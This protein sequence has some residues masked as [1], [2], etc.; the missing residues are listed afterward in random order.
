MDSDGSIKSGLRARPRGPRLFVA[1]YWKNNICIHPPTTH[2]Q[3]KLRCSVGSPFNCRAR[4]FSAPRLC[5]SF[6]V[7]VSWK[8]CVEQDQMQFDFSCATPVSVFIVAD[9]HRRS[10]MS[11]MAK[12]AFLLGTCLATSVQTDGAKHT[13]VQVRKTQLKDC[14]HS[15]PVQT[16]KQPSQR[17]SLYCLLSVLG[18][19]LHRPKDFRST[20]QTPKVQT[21]IRV[22]TLA[23]PYLGAHT[24]IAHD[25]KCSDS[26]HTDNNN[27]NNN[28]PT[29]S[30]LISP[31]I[32]KPNWP[33]KTHSHERGANG[34]FIGC[35]VVVCLFFATS[36]RNS[37]LL[38]CSQHEPGL[39]PAKKKGED[40][41]LLS[42]IHH[43]QCSHS[44]GGAP[45]LSLSGLIPVKN[46]RSTTGLFF[47]NFRLDLNWES[48]F[49]SKPHTSAKISWW[50]FLFLF[51]R[52]HSSCF[53]HA[54]AFYLNEI[55][56]SELRLWTRTAKASFLTLALQVNSVKNAEL[57]RHNGADFN[58]SKS[59]LS[60]I[61]VNTNIF[62]QACIVVCNSQILLYA[63][64]IITDHW[65]IQYC[66]IKKDRV[67]L[68]KR[69][70]TTGD[71]IW[72]Q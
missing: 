15:P 68:T 62:L 10:E 14:I 43:F 66:F 16:R 44:I 54:D 48:N 45:N 28:R 29:G 36:G 24:E 63:N 22:E 6:Y 70:K 1:R 37:I 9:D 52:K 4:T 5:L 23:T 13:Q 65:A 46:K 59:S 25:Q 38:A 19:I 33:P 53:S 42:G 50:F 47:I 27:N 58:F 8:M 64:V 72:T 56:Y 49:F 30:I 32:Q 26:L 55:E 21:R 40:R 35:N 67:C 3:C 17:N 20:D 7:S 60:N 31:D 2:F 11:K 41:I 51:W 57:N 34:D 71:P 69:H 61:S 39:K 12:P 18:F